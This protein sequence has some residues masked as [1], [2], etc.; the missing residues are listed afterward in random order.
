VSTQITVTTVVDQAPQPT[1][2]HEEI[3]LYKSRSNTST[4]NRLHHAQNTSSPTSAHAGPCHHPTTSP[5][6]CIAFPRIRI[7]FS[8][9]RLGETVDQQLSNERPRHHPTTSPIT[10]TAFPRIRISFSRMRLGETVDQQ[11]KRAED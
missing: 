5:I 8:G 6:T 4:N 1:T 10:C 3:P 11:G 7:S 2:A 9:M